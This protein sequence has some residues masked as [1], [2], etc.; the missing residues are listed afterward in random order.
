M[1]PIDGLS[2]T[3][4]YTFDSVMSEASNEARGQ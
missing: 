1:I 2:Q 4:I 3:L